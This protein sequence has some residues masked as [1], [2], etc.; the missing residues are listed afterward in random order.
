[1]KTFLTRLITI[2]GNIIGLTLFICWVIIYVF[3][4]LLHVILVHK[5]H[6]RL[7]LWKTDKENRTHALTRFFIFC[8]IISMIYI[9]F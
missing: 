9:I 6:K 5:T 3:D 4:R 2:L 1:M 7:G 8:F